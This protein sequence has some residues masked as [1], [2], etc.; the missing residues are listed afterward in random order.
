[1]LRGDPDATFFWERLL[2]RGGVSVVLVI[3]ASWLPVSGLVELGLLW[4][5]TVVLV[6][7]LLAPM[8]TEIIAHPVGLLFWPEDRPVPP[9]LFNLAARYA[10]VYLIKKTK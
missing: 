10:N 3:V 8:L 6:S 9:P 1:M 5:A 2:W 7:V 4:L